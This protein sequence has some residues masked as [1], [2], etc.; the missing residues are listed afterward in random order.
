MVSV[1]RSAAGL[2]VAGLVIAAALVFCARSVEPVRGGEKEEARGRRL[3]LRFREKEAR[4]FVDGEEWLAREG[5]ISSNRKSVKVCVLVVDCQPMQRTLELEPAGPTIVAFAPPVPAVWP[6][7]TVSDARAAEIA[8]GWQSAD[9]GWIEGPKVPPGSGRVVLSRLGMR[10]QVLAPRR[11]KAGETCVV[12][13]GPWLP[14][15]AAL[16]LLDLPP[17]ST[18]LVDDVA[19]AD[20]APVSPG[21]HVITTGAGRGARTAP[22]TVLPAQRVVR[23]PATI[24]RRDVIDRGLAWL[25]SHQSEDGRWSSSAFPCK[26]ATPCAPGERRH[27]VGVTGLALLALLG[28]DGPPGGGV[29]AD[30]VTKGID[31]LLRQPGT[32]GRFAPAGT[33]SGVYGNVI[34]ALAVIEQWGRTGDAKLQGSAVA[35]LWSILQDQ[36][37]YSGWRYGVRDGESDSSVTLWM[38]L[39]LTEAIATDLDPR[40]FGDLRGV[41]SRLDSPHWAGSSP[42]DALAWLDRLTDAAT[43]R[44]GYQSR[45]GP[46]AY[47]RSPSGVDP[48]ATTTARDWS[49]TSMSILVRR[50]LGALIAT[51]VARDDTIAA[52]LDAIRQNVPVGSLSTAAPTDVHAAYFGARVLAATDGA[53]PANWRVGFDELAKSQTATG[54][55]PP[56]QTWSPQGGAVY[57]TAMA[58]LALEQDRSR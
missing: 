54:G 21:S 44:V 7:I 55:F 9:F 1:F 4:I 41:R 19:A 18:V 6:T 8:I 11:L 27:D 17:G 5:V 22:L 42:R 30:A 29:H 45:G 52:G 3:E 49:S 48:A 50:R 39:A 43:G 58:L 12:E 15:A 24:A 33:R 32:D 57:T 13:P 40:P 38:A 35:A 20:G 31:F 14:R 10:S 47:H 26:C 16:D 37:P 25:V 53:L 2:G 28:A 51:G 56:D 36:N 46:Q 34:A 23:V